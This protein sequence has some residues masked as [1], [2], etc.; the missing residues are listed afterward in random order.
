[1]ITQGQFITLTLIVLKQYIC[2]ALFPERTSY[3]KRLT[4]K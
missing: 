2:I 3:Q 1:M 4:R